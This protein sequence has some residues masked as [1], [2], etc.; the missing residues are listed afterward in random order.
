MRKKRSRI[1]IIMDVLEA[2][3]RHGDEPASR[4]AMRANLA[5][6]RLSKIL[7]DLASRGLVERVNDGDRVVY[8]LTERGYAL[9]NE[10]RRLRR[11]LRD[12]GLDLI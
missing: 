2:L 12:F 5:Y 11:L 1:E 4:V 9:L 6:D 3:A 8:R 7:E 10:L